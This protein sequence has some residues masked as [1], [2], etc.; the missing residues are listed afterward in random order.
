MTQPLT[1]ERGNVISNEWVS[2]AT[3]EA[4]AE[5]RKETL[6][7]AEFRRRKA[8]LAAGRPK[9]DEAARRLSG[10]MEA[11]GGDVYARELSRATQA[12]SKDKQG[13]YVERTVG[14]EARLSRFMLGAFGQRGVGGLG[15]FK[16]GTSYGVPGLMAPGEY[17]EPE[18]ISGQQ[19]VTQPGEMRRKYRTSRGKL[20]Q[21]SFEGKIRKRSN[22]C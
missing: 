7:D 1:D 11:A 15:D 8:T 16:Q 12:G 5:S 14:Q 9:M 17:L 3:D 4:E 19:S 20:R 2:K 6:D 21:G 10:V 22:G 18:V 13:N